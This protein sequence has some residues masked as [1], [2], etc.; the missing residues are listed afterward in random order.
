MRDNRLAGL[1]RH[2]GLECRSGG[3]SVRGTRHGV[4]E[5]SEDLLLVVEVGDDAQDV[6]NASRELEQRTDTSTERDTV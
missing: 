4:V 3:T 2:E 6:T 5:V 1:K